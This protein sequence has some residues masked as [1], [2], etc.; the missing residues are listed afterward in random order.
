MLRILTRSVDSRLGYEY[1]DTAQR[2]GPPELELDQ[3]PRY[4]RM[5]SRS[6][7]PR[8]ITAKK[9]AP[10]RIAGKNLVPTAIPSLRGAQKGSSESWTSHITP[11]IPDHIKLWQA[12]QTDLPVI[13]VMIQE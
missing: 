12:A 4:T 11:V 7:D 2:P 13:V 1:T 8:N 6:N 9:T 10:F 3:K 5:F